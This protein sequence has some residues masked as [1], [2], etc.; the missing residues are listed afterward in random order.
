MSQAPAWI[1]FKI[2]WNLERAQGVIR[3]HC[4]I[5][6]GIWSR[7]PISAPTSIRYGTTWNVERCKDAIRILFDSA[8]YM[9]QDPPA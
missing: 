4:L 5:H 7:T 9:R 1:R 2:I 6:P 8:W 3:V